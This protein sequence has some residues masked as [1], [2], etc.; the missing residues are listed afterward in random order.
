[1]R[2]GRGPRLLP[3]D[4]RGE[5]IQDQ[6]RYIR[7]ALHEIESHLIVGSILASV[8]VLLFMRSWRS[9][10]IAAMAIPASI[11]RHVRGDEGDWTSR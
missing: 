11:D 1:M 9:T 2:L 4:M 5:V 8:I 10:L 6:S 7:A 3:T